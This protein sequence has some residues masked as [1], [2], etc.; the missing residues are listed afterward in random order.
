MNAVDSQH[1][2]LGSQRAALAIIL[3]L[4]PCSSSHSHFCVHLQDV[5]NVIFQK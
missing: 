5:C 4:K 1:L 3:A 2:V